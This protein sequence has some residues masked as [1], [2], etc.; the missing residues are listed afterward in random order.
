MEISTVL[1]V[2]TLWVPG[3]AA[4]TKASSAAFLD[5]YAGG[6]LSCTQLSDAH[7][8]D[9]GYCLLFTSIPACSGFFSLP[10]PRCNSQAAGSTPILWLFLG[11]QFGDPVI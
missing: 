11:A 3:A 2:L 7:L 6:I 4:E 1:S 10:R 5:K 9:I 8:L